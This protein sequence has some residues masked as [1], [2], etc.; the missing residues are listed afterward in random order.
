[1]L[2]ETLVSSFLLSLTVVLSLNVTI[3]SLQTLGRSSAKDRLMAALNADVEYQRGVIHNYKID[4]EKSPYYLSYL[5]EVSQCKSNTIGADFV[6]E[7]YP[8]LVTTLPNGVTREVSTEGP[9]VKF[10]YKDGPKVVYSSVILA[11]AA[12]WCP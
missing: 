10:L 5:P 2:V 6:A 7:T 11:P 4:K 1:M 12:S 3:T 8:D 9:L